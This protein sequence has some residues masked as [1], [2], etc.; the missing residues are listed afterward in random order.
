MSF[1]AKTLV[2]GESEMV[3]DVLKCSD[4]TRFTFRWLVKHIM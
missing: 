1:A 2:N 4:L 3:N